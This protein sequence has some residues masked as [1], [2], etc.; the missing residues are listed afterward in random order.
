MR[1]TRTTILALSSALCLLTPVLRPLAARA[2]TPPQI[3]AIVD[4]TPIII[5]APKPFIEVSRILPDAYAQRSAAAA[6]A[7]NRLLAWLIPALS[8]REQLDT[9]TNEKAPRCRM[10]QVQSVKDMELVRY[11]AASFKALRDE[12]KANNGQSLPEI[13][14]DTVEAIFG[15]LNL[16]QLGQ[17]AGGKKILGMADLGPDSFTLCI[18]IGTEGSD[19]LGGRDVETSVTCVTYVL[20]K[21]KII[22]LSVSGPEMT[23]KE[24]RNAMRLTREWLTLLRDRNPR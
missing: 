10:L 21:G 2:Q 15:V 8:L 12:T 7:G 22:Y 18:A 6:A 20:I 13:A 9:K 17:K 4:Q 3:V 19:Q 1:T 5:E 16:G 23:A 11:D 14:E 24:L